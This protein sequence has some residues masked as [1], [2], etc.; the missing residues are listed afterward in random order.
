MPSGCILIIDFD[1][2][3]SLWRQLLPYYYLDNLGQQKWPSVIMGNILSHYILCVIFYYIYPVIVNNNFY[4]Y[5]NQLQFTT[6]TTFNTN[7]HVNLDIYICVYVLLEVSPQ[8]PY[9]ECILYK[10]FCT[11]LCCHGIN[12]YTVHTR[13]STHTWLIVSQH[14][15]GFLHLK[16][17]ILSCFSFKMIMI[18]S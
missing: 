3:L 16:K 9:K 15:F 12:H 7:D 5:Y 1:I 17:C 14:V 11:A 13:S 8:R 2:F 4:H 10:Q 18:L 6:N